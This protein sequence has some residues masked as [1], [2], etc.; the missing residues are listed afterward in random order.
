MPLQVKN[1]NEPNMADI[2]ELQSVSCGK[3]YHT[4]SDSQNL[5]TYIKE[6]RDPLSLTFPVIKTK[7]EHNIADITKLQPVSCGENY[8]TFSDNHYLETDIKEEEDPLSI[9]SPVVKTESERV[10]VKEETE[11][12]ARP[13]TLLGIEPHTEK[14]CSTGKEYMSSGHNAVDTSDNLLIHHE[15]MKTHEQGHTRGHDVC[16]KSFIHKATLKRHLRVH[17]GERPYSCNVCK[18]SF[19]QQCHLN[20]HVRVHSGEHPYPCSVCR[21]CFRDNSALNKHMRV[22]DGERPYPCNV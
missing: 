1:E 15:S 3:T 6:E 10:A 14:F 17:S 11:S 20:R 9:T 8:H 16:K 7:T 13:H 12:P 5:Q 4:F 22:H 19:G 18:K 21:K 2:T